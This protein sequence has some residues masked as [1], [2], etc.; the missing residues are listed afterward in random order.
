MDNNK[1]GGNREGGGVGWGGGEGWEG[2]AE[3]CTWTTI[4]K[5]KENNRK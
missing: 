3:N 4:K 2:K 1:G 5:E